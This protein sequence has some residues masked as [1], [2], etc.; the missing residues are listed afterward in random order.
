MT[1]VRQIEIGRGGGGGEAKGGGYGSNQVG[2][3]PTSCMDARLAH[4][5]SEKYR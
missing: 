2:S 4:T 5:T 1:V 3:V